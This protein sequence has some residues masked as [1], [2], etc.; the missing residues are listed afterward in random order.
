LTIDNFNPKS[1]IQNLKYSITIRQSS[2]LKGGGLNM[3]VFGGNE[4]SKDVLDRDLCIGCGACMEIC[5]YLK[6]YKGKTAM[7]FP[8]TLSEGRCHAHCPKVE[9]NLDDLSRQFFDTSYGEAPLGSY[10][11]VKTARAGEQIG[12]GDFQAGGTVSALMSFAIKKGAIDAAVMTHKDGIL[13]M[14]ILTTDPEAVFKC[15]SSKYTAAPTL[16]ACNQA[17]NKGYKRI[18]V[19]AT[20]CQ[21]LAL[22]QLRSNP[23][24]EKE[25]TDPV[26]LIVGLFCT[27]ALDFRAFEAFISERMDVK[28]ITKFDIPPPPSEIMEVFAGDEKIEIPLDEIR[29]LVP[30]TCSYCIDMTSEFSDIAVGVLEGR[31]DMN[32][33]LIRTER[34]QNIVDQAQKEGYLIVDEI[35][36][37]NLE[38]LTWAAGNK[39]KKALIKGKQD[40]LLDTSEE[41]GSPYLRLDPNTMEKIIA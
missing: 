17:I 16:L 6:S 19:V 28:K 39:K 35:P 11:Y 9:V 23:L 3:R 14:P 37:E 29:Q 4:L 41:A 27:W 8:C 21:A 26:G 34:G 31:P 40:G 13:P 36:Q 1:K 25:F 24:E 38:H 7:L 30:N 22:A 12:N 10:R 5:P 32:T 2:I 18:G 33:L 20:P 15:S